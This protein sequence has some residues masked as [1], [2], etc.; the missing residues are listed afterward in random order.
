MPDPVPR[1]IT[2]LIEEFGRLPTIGP[3]TAQRLAFFLLRAPTAQVAALGAA[4][5]GLREHVVACTRCGNYAD[6]DP[7][8]ICCDPARDQQQLCVVEDPLDLLA[9]ERSGGFNGIYHVLHGVIAPLD[10]V[11][12]DE[13]NLLRAWSRAFGSEGLREVIVAT[14]ASIEGDATAAYINS[15]LETGAVVVSRLARGL[16]RGGDIEYVDAATIAMA[17][18]GRSRV[19]DDWA[20]GV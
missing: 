17:L 19:A 18:E 2:R 7:C 10:G 4:V 15:M 20:H 1:P 5:T 14:N 6:Q 3:K 16:A 12:P 13:L 8:S 11:G 9:I